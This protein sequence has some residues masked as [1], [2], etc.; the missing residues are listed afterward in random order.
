MPEILE[1]TEQY[2]SPYNR[3]SSCQIEIDCCCKD[4]LNIWETDHNIVGDS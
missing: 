4:I 3:Q 2:I 1:H